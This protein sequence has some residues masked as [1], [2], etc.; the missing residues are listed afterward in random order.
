MPNSLRFLLTHTNEYEWIVCPVA[1]KTD[2]HIANPARALVMNGHG[3]EVEATQGFPEPRCTA[4]ARLPDR[5]PA[6]HL[7]LR[8]IEAWLYYLRNIGRISLDGGPASAVPQTIPRNLSITQVCVPEHGQGWLLEKAILDQRGIRSAADLLRLAPRTSI[9]GIAMRIGK[10]DEFR[11]W[12]AARPMDSWLDLA[13][14]L[15]LPLISLADG[16]HAFAIAV[17]DPGHG[18]LW[19]PGAVIQEHCHV[20]VSREGQISAQTRPVDA[21]GFEPDAAGWVSHSQLDQACQAEFGLTPLESLES[22]HDIVRTILSHLLSNRPTGVYA[23]LVSGDNA[24]PTE[25]SI[26][27]DAFMAPL[28]ED[29]FAIEQCLRW[30]VYPFDGVTRPT[31]LASWLFADGNP[32]WQERRHQA[33][34]AMP[35]AV[36]ALVLEGHAEALV[37]IDEAGPLV[38]AIRE[39]YGVPAWTARRAIS[40]RSTHNGEMLPGP[41]TARRLPFSTA[42]HRTH[43]LGLIAPELPPECVGGIQYLIDWFGSNR[44]NFT[45]PPEVAR[46]VLR[47]LG[48]LAARSG[49]LHASRLVSSILRHRVSLSL[50]DRIM[51]A[52]VSAYLHREALEGETAAT[53]IV[54]AWLENL[55]AQSWLRRSKRLASLHWTAGEPGLTHALEAAAREHQTM[56]TSGPTRSSGSAKT[57]L[58]PF[59]CIETRV[60]IRP[61]NTLAALQAQAARM[62]NCLAGRWSSVRNHE[63]VIIALETENSVLCAS[64]ALAMDEEHVWRVTQI[65][66]ASNS[67]VE[68]SSLLHVAANLLAQRMSSHPST[69]DQAALEACMRRCVDTF[70]PIDISAYAELAI[71]RLPAPLAGQV[72]AC[73]PG[74]GDLEKRIKHA[75]QRAQ[76]QQ[77]T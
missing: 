34:K 45:P 49:W 23:E 12:I 51:T 10:S 3:I 5:S 77:L 24:E 4:S 47:A 56:P 55:D 38:K 76:K 71:Q 58:S 14:P 9:A 41:H 48:I 28:H 15:Y 36:T 35:H 27:I 53:D 66:G 59:S 74:S 50:L 32:T 26:W 1:L 31:P 25:L 40:W 46:R 21:F 70:Q 72:L 67:S 39:T 61:L 65:R 42:L 29:L 60:T 22:L 43:A 30:R 33:L 8:V 18:Y 19:L 63:E 62:H 7:D 68:Q 13:T 17:R 73:L 52:T 37:A 57:L 54:D 11:Q 16:A 64:A 69:L 6:M 2:L 44:R 75:I 20:H